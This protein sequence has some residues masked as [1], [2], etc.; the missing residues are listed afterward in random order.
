[1]PAARSSTGLGSTHLSSTQP[2]PETTASDYV[3]NGL[4]PV[5]LAVATAP[6]RQIIERSNI[7]AHGVTLLQ[8]G[9]GPAQILSIPRDI[10]TNRPAGLISIGT[11]GGLSGELA[12]G[13]LLLPLQVGAEDGQVFSISSAWHARVCQRLDKHNIETGMLTSVSNAV[14]LPRDKQLLQAKTGAVAVDMESA[15]LARIA[16]HNSIPFLVVRA[17]A[18]PHDQQIPSSAMTALTV[19]GDTRIAG[20]LSQ[21]LLHPREISGM[22]RLRSN[23]HAAGRSLDA[24]CREAG[25][26]ISCPDIQ[27]LL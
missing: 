11:A 19:R 9:I 1:M 17:V 6:E 7:T 4:S 21:L 23:F 18:D 25:E 27:P 10:W 12:P 20:L 24:C 13:Q 26:E 8:T 15:A 16:H 5:I 2:L 22:L 3:N 14:R